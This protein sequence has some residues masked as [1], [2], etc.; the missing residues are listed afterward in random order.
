MTAVIF[1]PYRTDWLM[2]RN[3]IRIL[4]CLLVKSFGYMERMVVLVT[5]VTRNA[6]VV[7]STRLLMA[8]SVITWR[9][10]GRDGVSN[11]QPRH[12]L[13]KRLF[14]RRSKKTSRLRVTGLCAGNSQVTGEFPAQRASNAENVSI[15]WRHHV[16]CIN[17]LQNTPCSSPERVTYGILF[18]E[19]K[20]LRSFI[21]S[22]FVVAVSFALFPTM[23]LNISFHCCFNGTD[24][25]A[26]VCSSMKVP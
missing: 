2:R 1:H 22:V 19:L 8:V 13:L 7:S 10:N 17:L 6:V 11:H 24:K 5:D 15:W 4:C 16:Q 18:N 25:P 23:L 12:C 26:L 9:Y 21:E 3:K 20:M 14:S